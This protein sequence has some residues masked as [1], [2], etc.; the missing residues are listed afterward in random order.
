MASVLITGGAGFF[1]GILKWRLLEAGFDCVSIDLQPDGETHPNLVSV[2]GDVRDSAL[3]DQL[4]SERRFDAVFHCAAILAHAVKDEGLLWSCNV[5]GTRALGVAMARHQVPRVVFVSSNCLFARNFGRPVTEDDDPCPIEVYGRSKWEGEKV[6]ATFSGSFETVSVRTP[7][8][9]DSGRLGLLAILFEFIREGRR[10]WVVGKG[11]NRYQFVYAADLADAC[12]AALE[13]PRASVY[14]VGS[15]DVR[16]LREVYQYVIDRAGTSARVASL[17]KRPA[18][19][20]MRL[21]ST[22]RISPLGP[23]HYRMIAESFEFDTSRI[24]AELAWEPTLTNEEMLWKA[25]EHFSANV[26]EIMGRTEVSAHRQPAKMGAIR[27]LK[28]LS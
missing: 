20:A 15:D 5:E 16:S 25:Y 12:V 2:R 19:A 9:V 3:L 26:E 14:N 7:T 8:I 1:G 6:L 10:A 18:L 13:A 23:Y 27:I 22:L 24:K 17:P 21:A 4:F 11:D 28:W